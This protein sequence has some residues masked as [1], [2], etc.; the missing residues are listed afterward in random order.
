MADTLSLA[1]NAQCKKM[2]GKLGENWPSEEKVKLSQALIKINRKGKE[3]QR[4]MLITDKAIYNLM[5]RDLSKCRRR[6]RLENVASVTFST[7]SQEFAIHVPEEYDYRFKAA[8]AQAKKQ[9]QETLTAV[10][11]QKVKS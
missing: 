5:P 11:N 9:V 8:S 3:Q 1:S 10:Y 7:T 2:L 6:I 4:V